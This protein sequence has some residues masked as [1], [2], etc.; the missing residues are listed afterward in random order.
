MTKPDRDALLRSLEDFATTLDRLEASR[1][2]VAAPV[3]AQRLD[4]L[5]Q[6]A[7]GDEILVAMVEKLRR[8]L[9]TGNELDG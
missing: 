2:V 5:E 1:V 7:Q 8:R 6:S 9:T 3:L 4:E